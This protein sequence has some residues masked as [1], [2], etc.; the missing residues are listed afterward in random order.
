[1]L[2]DHFTMLPGFMGVFLIATYSATLS[3]FSTFL[4]STAT[5]LLPLVKKTRYAHV[6]DVKMSKILIVIIGIATFGLA[7]AMRKVSN[8]SRFNHLRIS[9]C[10]KPLKFYEGNNDWNLICSYRKYWSTIFWLLFGRHAHSI[11]EYKGLTSI[12][13]NLAAPSSGRYFEVFYRERWP[14]L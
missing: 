9:W 11:F 12:Y 1:M 7:V 8:F 3:S 10:L 6:E 13:K 5:V 14:D 2:T 4:S